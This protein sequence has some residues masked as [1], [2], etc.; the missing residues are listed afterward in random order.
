MACISKGR[1]KKLDGEPVHLDDV[2]LGSLKG[3]HGDKAKLMDSDALA[4]DS[5]ANGADVEEDSHHEDALL[6][7][8]PDKRK[9]GRNGSQ[10][11]R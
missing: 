6:S 8:T 10:E 5:P 2:E 9:A 7:G 3:L 11:R 1:I 4:S